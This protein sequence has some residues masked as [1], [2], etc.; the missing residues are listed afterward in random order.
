M[1]RALRSGLRSGLSPL[2]VLLGLAALSGCSGAIFTEIDYREGQVPPV[3]PSNARAPETKAA[4]LEALGAPQA[5]LP[6]RD[7]DVFVYRLS[8]VD[9]E[10]INVN[11][12]IFTGITLP[13]YARLDGEQHDQLVYVFFDTEGRVRDLAAGRWL[14]RP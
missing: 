2:A 8:D 1:M 10:I 4:I 14:P 5:Y 9:I 7:G 3:P 6:Q 12:G 13:I 11:S